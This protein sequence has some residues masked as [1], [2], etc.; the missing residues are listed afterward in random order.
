MIIDKSTKDLWQS[1]DELCEDGK[2][3]AIFDANGIETINDSFNHLA[4][5]GRLIAYGM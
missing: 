1:V 5:A 3:A 2:F 4:P